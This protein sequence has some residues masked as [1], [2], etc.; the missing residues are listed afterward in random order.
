MLY[1]GV[2]HARRPGF[3]ETLSGLPLRDANWLVIGSLMAAGCY[4]LG[5]SLAYRGIFLLFVMTGLLAFERHATTTGMVTLARTAQLLLPP[6]MWMDAVIQ[7]GKDAL[8]QGQHGWPGMLINLV[9]VVREVMWLTL[10]GPLV[11]VILAFFAGTPLGARGPAMLRRS[12]T[13]PARP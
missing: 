7:F 1:L 5:P 2:H 12:R 9:W 6:L 13:A 11:G 8:A 4:L 3:R 10:A